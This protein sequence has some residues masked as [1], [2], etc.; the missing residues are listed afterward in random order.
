MN[1]PRV[2]VTEKDGVEAVLVPGGYVRVGVDPGLVRQTLDQLKQPDEPVF[3]T[4]MPPREV[5]IRD[6]Y[7]DR[8]PVTNRV[9]AQFMNATGHEA[10]SFWNH[11][12]WNAPDKPVVGVSSLDAQ[13][14][15]RWAGKRLPTEEEWEAAARGTDGRIWPW[16]DEFL[17]GRCNSAESGA[18]HTTEV[19][20]FPG[21]VSPVGAFD[22]AGNVWELTTGNWEGF[23]SAIRG[24][25]FRNSAAYCRCTCRWGID[26]AVRESNWLGFRCVMDL[27]KARI[28]GRPLQ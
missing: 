10:P 1:L 21:G 23:G 12:R 15:A 9:F 14:Y 6:C 16:G 25:S 7:I 4:E 22:M 5:V 2:I 18:G 13:A 8:Y 26:P 3:S 17:P 28:Y 11:P 27:A 20:R 24:G 19:T